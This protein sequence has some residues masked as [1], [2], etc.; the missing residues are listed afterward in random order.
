MKLE[1][2]LPALERLIG[3]DTEIEIGIRQQIAN[4]FASR[5]LKSLLNSTQMKELEQEWRGLIEEATRKRFQEWKDS[6]EKE[7]PLTSTY[8]GCALKRE[9]NDAVN[10]AIGDVLAEAVK[11]HMD[12]Y[13]GNWLFGDIKKWLPERLEKFIDEEIKR[14]LERAKEG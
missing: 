12:S 6:K 10:K 2:N 11:K 7:N 3:G 8:P 5:H 4:E 13:I 9:I 1:L 14:R